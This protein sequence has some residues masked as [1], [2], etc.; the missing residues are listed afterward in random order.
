ML[1]ATH[2]TNGPPQQVD[3]IQEV[4]VVWFTMRE[5]ELNESFSLYTLYRTWLA[6]NGM[7]LMRDEKD[8]FSSKK[9]LL[10]A[11]HFAIKREL[12]KSAQKPLPFEEKSIVLPVC[13]RGTQERAALVFSREKNLARN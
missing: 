9:K 8:N 7:Q 13:F 3:S 11:R 1:C 6:T 4:S 10:P 5:R 12:P 2:T